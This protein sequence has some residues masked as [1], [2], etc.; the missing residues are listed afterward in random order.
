MQQRMKEHHHLNIGEQFRK[1]RKGQR[2]E[3]E[4]LK[5]GT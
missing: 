5:V 2:A 1:I 4:A 3:Q